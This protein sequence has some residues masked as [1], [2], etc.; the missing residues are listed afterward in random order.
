MVQQNISKPRYKLSSITKTKIWPNKDGYLRRFFDLRAFRLK[1]RGLFIRNVL[2]AKT[3]KWTD[4]RRRRWPARSIT[5]QIK[6]AGRVGKANFWR[7]RKRRYRNSFYTKQQLRFYYGKIKEDAFRHYFKNYKSVVGKPST[8]FFSALESRLD[9]VFFHR[10]LLPTIYACHQYIHHK[11]LL[12]NGSL[13]K[14]PRTQV[15]IGDTVSIPATIWNSVYWFLFHRVYYR[16]WGLYIYRRRLYTQLKKKVFSI[17][18]QNRNSFRSFFNPSVS[19]K[20]VSE[21]KASL[22][23]RLLTSKSKGQY[24][25]FNKSQKFYIKTIKKANTL[26]NS[27]RQTNFKGMHKTFFISRKS[28]PFIGFTSIKRVF[29]RIKSPFLSN[30]NFKIKVKKSK[31]PGTFPAV[32][33]KVFTDFG[34]FQEYKRFF[35]KNKINKLKYK[36]KNKVKV[37]YKFKYKLKKKNRIFTESAT[38]FSVKSLVNNS[39][40][41][42]PYLTVREKQRRLNFDKLAKFKELSEDKWNLIFSKFRQLQKRFLSLRFSKKYKKFKSNFSNS[43]KFKGVSKKFT[44]NNFFYKKFIQRP[45]KKKKRLQLASRRKSVHLYIPSYL[46][47]DFRTLRAIK[48]K[49]P[50]VEEIYHPFRGS[51]AKRRSFYYSRGR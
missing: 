27:S 16:R 49:S 38:E 28:N 19:I 9:R 23:F 21:I 24:Y 37:K 36:A 51:F 35:F 45:L 31:Q 5:R 20:S 43:F 26:F 10:R 3:R 14:S 48:I 41:R 25:S 32:T 39:F 46:Q 2:V 47:M 13:E 17:Q 1:R 11:G 29:N 22:P 50:V 18:N 15:L 33:K 30:N 44:N 42:H 7:A 34:S 4:V 12:I 40:D 8:F 6:V